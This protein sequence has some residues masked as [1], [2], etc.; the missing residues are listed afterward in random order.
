MRLQYLN[1]FSKRLRRLSKKDF[2]LGSHFSFPQKQVTPRRAL[3]LRVAGG[4]LLELII[5]T[6]ILVAMYL[7]KIAKQLENQTLIQSIE[8]KNIY[9][10]LNYS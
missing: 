1:L 10:R 7:F 3:I 9:C 2:V 5:A 4:V 8:F 6:N